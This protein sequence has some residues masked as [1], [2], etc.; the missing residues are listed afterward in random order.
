MCKS[1][2]YC[3]GVIV[4]G[5]GKIVVSKGSYDIEGNGNVR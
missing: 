4:D 2:Y 5:G 1:S 3:V